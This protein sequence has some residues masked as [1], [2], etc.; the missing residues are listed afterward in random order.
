MPQ[1][2]ALL[3]I[4]PAAQAV[5][6]HVDGQEVVPPGQG[7]MDLRGVA[8]ADGVGHALLDDPVQGVLLVL[9]KGQ[10]PGFL[11]VKDLR[12]GGGLEVGNHGLQGL[13]QR[14][15]LQGVGPQGL[16]GPAH[17]VEPVPGRLGHHLDALFRLLRRGVKE[18]QSRVGAHDDARQRVAQGVVNLTG[19][20]VPLPDLR[21]ALQLKGVV[22]EAVVGLVQLFVQLPYAAVLRLLAGEQKNHKEDEQKY[23]QAD[24]QTLRPGEEAADRLVVVVQIGAEGDAPREG[25]QDFVAPEGEQQNQRRREA[26]AVKAVAHIV[27]QVRQHQQRRS[28]VVKFQ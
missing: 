19:Q 27:D 23:V 12:R 5:V 3:H 22:P 9:G 8:V 20:A 4:L 25:I 10:G 13:L 6:P 16:D 15:V 18:G 2:E 7:N 17:V 28:A 1:A 21:H 14:G 26:D 11:L 24:Q